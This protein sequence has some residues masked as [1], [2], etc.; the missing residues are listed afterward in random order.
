MEKAGIHPAAA[1]P[2]MPNHL[3]GSRSDH[4]AGSRILVS[5]C[6][7]EFVDCLDFAFKIT[8]LFYSFFVLLDWPCPDPGKGEHSVYEVV[9]VGS[10][11]E[12][13]YSCLAGHD[14]GN[15]D[16]NRSCGDTRVWTGTPLSCQGK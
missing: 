14:Y 3:D 4:L 10:G 5:L 1:V 6:A 11:E 8:S 9:D 13:N 16:F 7:I 12:A 2:S 15:G